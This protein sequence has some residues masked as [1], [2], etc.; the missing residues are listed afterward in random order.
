MRNAYKTKK[1]QKKLIHVQV[2]FARNCQWK[3][4]LK[5]DKIMAISYK[6]YISKYRRV[7]ARINH[8]KI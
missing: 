2:M 4:S 3:Y 1:Q 5:I 7:A 8:D 6:I